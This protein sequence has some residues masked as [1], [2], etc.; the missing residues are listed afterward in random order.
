MQ[1]GKRTSPCGTDDEI[2][3]QQ[4]RTLQITVGYSC[5]CTYPGL[6]SQTTSPTRAATSKNR[7][8]TPQPRENR[9]KHEN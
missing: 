7:S 9:A 3:Q 1:P 2:Q 4:A 6:P 8:T 5:A